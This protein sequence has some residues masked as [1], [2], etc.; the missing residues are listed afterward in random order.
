MYLCRKNKVS[1]FL[2]ISVAPFELSKLRLTAFKF[3]QSVD[4]VS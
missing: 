1:N 3:V 2:I 4:V